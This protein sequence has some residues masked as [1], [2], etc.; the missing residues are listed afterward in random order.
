MGLLSDVF[1]A[2]NVELATLHPGAGG[3]EGHF[4]TVSGKRID[5]IKLATL[6]ASVT[7][8]Q[9]DILSLAEAWDDEH[10]LVYSEEEEQVCRFPETLS[11]ALTQLPPE[12]LGLCVEA[13]AATEEWRLD[14]G[15]TPAGR[16]TLLRWLSAVCQ[17]A[18]RGQREGRSLCIWWSL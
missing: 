9:G 18:R 16:E 4:P 13:W 3:P 8:Y 5:S 2:S 11:V 1:L 7:Q 6:E 17:L 12:A 15:D 10:Y 14:G